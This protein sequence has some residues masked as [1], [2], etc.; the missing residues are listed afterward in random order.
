VGRT[1]KGKI[2]EKSECENGHWVRFPGF[3]S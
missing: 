2:T 3:I 1:K